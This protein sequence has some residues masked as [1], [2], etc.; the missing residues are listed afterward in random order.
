M[1][2]TVRFIARAY[3]LVRSGGLQRA[4]HAASAAAASALA[5]PGLRYFRT[6]LDLPPQPAGQDRDS[7]WSVELVIPF[8]EPVAARIKVRLGETEAVLW[9][10]IAGANAAAESNTGFPAPGGHPA[11]KA[12][13]TP[14]NRHPDGG[15]VTVRLHAAP[16]TR[17]ETGRATALVSLIGAGPCPWRRRV[18]AFLDSARCAIRGLRSERTRAYAATPVS[19]AYLRPLP[20]HRRFGMDHENAAL[21]IVTGH[22]MSFVADAEVLRIV[23]ATAE[24][25]QSVEF[26][27]PAQFSRESKTGQLLI[28]YDL[29]ADDSFRDL[30]RR[31]HRAFA[32][33]TY[34]PGPE[35]RADDECVR[36]REAAAGCD[37]L[38]ERESDAS[39]WPADPDAG[40]RRLAMPRTPGETD[41][42]DFLAAVRD[43]YRKRLLPFF[44]V[45]VCPENSGG[46]AETMWESLRRQDYPGEW[47][48]VLVVPESPSAAP[49]SLRNITPGSARADGMSRIDVRAVPCPAAAPVTVRKNIGAGAAKG[50][51]VV[52]AAPDGAVP[53]S[54]LAVFART[55]S[56]GDCEVVVPETRIAEEAGDDHADQFPVGSTAEQACFLD[57]G[58]LNFAVRRAWVGRDPFDPNLA[59]HEWDETLIAWDALEFGYRLYAQG[60]R[61]RR[62]GAAEVTRGTTTISRAA[63]VAAMVSRLAERHEE[64]PLLTR[65]WLGRLGDGPIPPPRG[66]GA[67]TPSCVGSGPEP[68]PPARE[69]RRKLKI[70]TYRWHVPHQYELYKLPHEFVLVADV[71]E[72]TCAFWDLSQR[73]LQANVRLALIRDVNPRDFDLA[74][75]HF[76]ENV[77]RPA[78]SGGVLGEDWGRSFRWFRENLPIPLIGVCHGAPRFRDQFDRSTPLRP[79]LE[80]LDDERRQMV[81]YVGDMPVAVNSHQAQKEWDFRNSCVIWHGFDPIEFPPASF[82]KGILSLSMDALAA[83]P[84]SRGYFLLQQVLERV[85]HDVAVEGLFVPEPHPLYQGNEYARARFRNYVD[86]LRQYSVYF[87]PTLRSPMPRSRGEAMVCGLAVVTANNYD[88]DLFITNGENGFYSNDPLELAD[89]LLFLARNP[90]TARQVGMAGRRLALDVFGLDRYH[91]AWTQ[92]IRETVG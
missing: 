38:L 2:N 81:D 26:A 37:F 11:M 89:M 88:V 66:S 65:R 63:S 73:P 23:L 31:A 57:C 54:M 7:V 85:S 6:Q 60:A 33:V 49:E 87:N 69:T 18:S 13:L 19:G 16:D 22:S 51:I 41:I 3:R 84:H 76:D 50:D 47:E 61:F 59:A 74:I 46:V 29:V 58:L 24:Q 40:P 1:S 70:L 5:E 25:F 27:T 21:Q 71:G 30:L 4:L 80:I 35:S 86:A 77:L 83:L 79:P 36:R 20:A 72:S 17:W 10:R 8:D 62:A 75:L 14:G 92:L 52:F 45:I 48:I 32:P 15:R 67:K 82:K 28:V 9:P 12:C 64:F 44:S 68:V 43:G 53:E 39:W 42:R 56:L 55:L 78:D 91:Q 34:L 90:A